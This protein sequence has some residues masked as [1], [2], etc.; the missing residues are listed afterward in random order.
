MGK[1]VNFE[2]EPWTSTTAWAT[3]SPC[4]QLLYK[5][6]CGKMLITNTRMIFMVKAQ[7]STTKLQPKLL[8]HSKIM[9]LGREVGI[10]S[11]AKTY[12]KAATTSSK[13]ATICGKSFKQTKQVYLEF[14]GVVQKGEG[15]PRLLQSV[16]IWWQGQGLKWDVGGRLCRTTAPASRRLQTSSLSCQWWPSM[17]EQVHC[18]P[19]TA[20]TKITQ[21]QLNKTT[22]CTA[23]ARTPRTSV[24]L[25]VRL[26][27]AD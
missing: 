6:S 1:R 23:Q 4:P 12:C 27:M 10:S 19:H 21:C 3:V 5:I 22:T 14:R 13:Y 16:H 11:C 17:P 25:W 9:W 24:H 7:G 18:L 8:L 26:S 20:S 15:T 2:K